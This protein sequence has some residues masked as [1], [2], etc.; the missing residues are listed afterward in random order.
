[1]TTVV[2]RIRRFG[3]GAVPLLDWR[4]IGRFVLLLASRPEASRAKPHGPTA[5]RRV[6][7]RPAQDVPPRM[8][9]SDT[10]QHKA[11]RD[12]LDLTGFREELE[13]LREQMNRASFSGH[14][15]AARQ[16]IS[17][18]EGVGDASTW[19]QWLGGVANQGLMQDA[20]TTAV[21]LLHQDDR[22]REQQGARALAGGRL[23]SQR[24]PPSHSAANATADSA[25]R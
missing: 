21:R 2:S 17:D 25:E 9:G 22:P 15:V 11:S 8:S 19:W 20:L 1:V 23:A 3:L 12:C 7:L 4:P 16:S 18:D 5:R 13:A 10:V 24:L 6:A 14:Q